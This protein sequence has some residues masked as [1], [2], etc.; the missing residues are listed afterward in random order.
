MQYTYYEK[1][2]HLNYTQLCTD[3]HE[4]VHVAFTMYSFVHVLN[5]HI[6]KCL[7]YYLHLTVNFIYIHFTIDAYNMVHPVQQCCKYIEITEAISFVVPFQSC[8]AQPLHCSSPLFNNCKCCQTP[9]GI[10]SILNFL[11]Q[12]QHQRKM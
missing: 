11:H 10:A 2:V 9:N 1:C 8:T 3:K 5:I 6:R 4:N 12:K 7:M